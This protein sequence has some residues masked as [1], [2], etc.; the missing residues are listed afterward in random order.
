MYFDRVYRAAL[1]VRITH[2]LLSLLEAIYLVP[3][4]A[5]W[6]RSAAN[7]PYRPTLLPSPVY[8]APL[9]RGAQYVYSELSAVATIRGCEGCHAMFSTFQLKFMPAPFSLRPA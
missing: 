3:R 2:L 5:C 8:A 7:K 6:H 9:L 1:L 4:N